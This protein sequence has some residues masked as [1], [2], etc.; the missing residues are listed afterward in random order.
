MESG[1]TGNSE[2]N[3]SLQL[4]FPT[5][6]SVIQTCRQKMS[7]APMLLNFSNFPTISSAQ[8]KS[9]LSQQ[10]VI[11]PNPSASNQQV[12]QTSQLTDSKNPSVGNAKQI[13]DTVKDSADV[14][15]E[16]TQE[17][18]EWSDDKSMKWIEVN[19]KSLE[20][21]TSIINDDSE[22]EI[23]LMDDTLGT[24]SSTAMH[25]Y[26]KVPVIEH[27]RNQQKSP[28]K[29]TKKSSSSEKNSANLIEQVECYKC[30]FCMFLSLSE[31]AVAAHVEQEHSSQI[32]TES[33]GSMQ[34]PGCSNIFFS[35][36]S[37]R[38]HLSEDHNV[39]QE[40]LE[41]I[42]STFQTNDGGVLKNQS[43]L[44]SDLRH[45]EEQISL[46]ACNEVIADEMNNHCYSGDKSSDIQPL[47]STCLK[48]GSPVPPQ[49]ST[50]LRRSVMQTNAALPD[51]T[52]KIRVRKM[53]TLEKSLKKNTKVEVVINSSPPA[54]IN[55]AE[56]H[57][58]ASGD[59]HI[60]M[61]MQYDIESMQIL[62]IPLGH[63][64]NESQDPGDQQLNPSHSENDNSLL[65]L[66]QDDREQYCNASPPSCDA[67]IDEIC[68]EE[69]LDS[70]LYV[71]GGDLLDDR[72][73]PIVVCF[74]ASPNNI[75]ED[76][77]GYDI[78]TED[79]ASTTSEGPSLDN[80]SERI[81]LS[82]S[83]FFDGTDIVG[84]AGKK[85][86]KRG[87]VKKTSPT[88]SRVK[89]PKVL[90]NDPKIEEGRTIV[91]YKCGAYGC[92]VRMRSYENVK[93]HQR[94]HVE[95]HISEITLKD[96]ADEN[97]PESKRRRTV[98][99]K[100]TF[101]CPE[102]SLGMHSWKLMKSHL[103]KS[104]SIDMEL[105][106]CDQCGYKTPSLSNMNNIHVKIHGSEKPYLCDTCGK[107]FKTTKQLGNHKVIHSRKES[108][109]QTCD[110]CGRT[111]HTNRML[112]NHINTV[113]NKVRPYMCSECGHTAANR[114]SLKMHLRQ[115]T[116]DRPYECDQCEYTTADHNSLRRHKKRHTG[117]KPY[118][119]PF[120]TY[121]CIQSSTYKVH[122]RSK[123]PG[124]NLGLM[125][126]CKKCSFHSVNHDI[127]LAHTAEH[128]IAESS[129]IPFKT[130]PRPTHRRT[131]KHVKI[132][133]DSPS[134]EMPIFVS[135]ATD[136]AAIDTDQPNFENIV[137][138]VS[139]EILPGSNLHVLYNSISLSDPNVKTL[140]DSSTSKPAVLEDPV[141]HIVQDESE[142]GLVEENDDPDA[143][144]EIP[145]EEYE[146][147]VKDTEAQLG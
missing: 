22:V 35:Q 29:R 82:S 131:A 74:A 84:P 121:A 132:S 42:L 119:C 9:M 83:S 116:G 91:G 44:E 55:L 11:Q 70:V 144:I 133:D 14:S 48:K 24:T 16:S 18:Y 93:Y 113:H 28:K 86:V 66:G 90:K 103:W 69:V 115:H 38:V 76:S 58:D 43:N 109:L 33:N 64:S 71:Q 79:N 134:E 30:R 111:F 87:F 141:V 137:Q 80:S 10:C 61:D 142:L 125:F 108:G 98:N 26:S 53:S 8:L 96:A 128:D 12:L 126:S 21:E 112:R 118:K 114:S 94:C 15:L 147:K 110:T 25:T 127:Y 145:T 85:L 49:R 46:N 65:P 81:V 104:H 59:D 7:T 41:H 120:C 1:T 102:C 140:R 62:D 19:A 56:S 13:C 34:C 107:G 63:D 60:P 138:H 4:S 50:A 27:G 136:E 72:D 2:Q 129:G 135:I 88:K 146:F 106:T 100:H 68:Q 123:H 45:D 3:S 97:I 95:G 143:I 51:E 52:G 139:E 124:Q 20:A 47:K 77:N 5:P 122:L 31:E 6:Q 37:L 67:I 39:A 57:E 130:A 78:Q 117:D 17:Q 99:S 75:S 36:K 89:K 73:S 105:Y 92:T 32:P 54:Q 40:E 101:D 23:L